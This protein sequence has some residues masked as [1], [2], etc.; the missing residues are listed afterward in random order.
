MFDPICDITQVVYQLSLLRKQRD[1]ITHALHC[2][3]G[4][5][6][7]VIYRA[8]FPYLNAIQH[9]AEHRA[10]QRRTDIH[11][12]R[13]PDIALRLQQRPSLR[14]LGLQARNI[15]W[16]PRRMHRHDKLLRH[17]HPSQSCN[18]CTHAV[19]LQQPFSLKLQLVNR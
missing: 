12:P 17:D 14:R 8:H 3:L 16:M 5:P 10:T 1:T 7:R 18:I 2:R 11:Q 6:R 15:I 19:E 13:Q 4:D 9:A